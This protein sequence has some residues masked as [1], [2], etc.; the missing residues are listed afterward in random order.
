MEDKLKENYMKILFF[1]NGSANPMLGGIQAV[2]YYL[3]YYFKS[4]GHEVYILSVFR[5][6]DYKNSV[7]IYFPDQENIKGEMNRIFLI[8][9]IQEK[10][11]EIVVNQSCLSP[12]LS[13]F[14]P[15]IKATGIRLVSVFHSQ[16]YGVYGINNFPKIYNAIS[17]K[18]M[19]SIIDKCIHFAFKIK[20]G[21]HFRRILK[22]S[23][24]QVMLSEKFINEFIYFSSRKYKEKVMAI[25]NPLTTSGVKSGKKE[26]IVLFVGRI[27]QGKGVDIILKIWNYI[28]HNEKYKDWK[29][30]IVG[31]GE[32]KKELEK[33]AI[34]M[35][36]VNYSFKGFQKPDIYYDQAKIFCMASTFEGFG[37][38]L[39]EAMYYGAVPL[40]FNSFSNC[41]DIIDDKQNG[42]LVTP[43]SIEEYIQK[44]TGLMEDEKK[45]TTMS[46]CAMH[47]SQEFSIE[48]IGGK[49]LTLFKILLE[50]EKYI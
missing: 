8:D 42:F 6:T 24:R 43:F 32:E 34:E 26:K 9:F 39:I 33:L 13:I 27:C 22:Y 38:V 11:I 35:Q 1:N 25:P 19:R 46:I 23:D 7:Q 12:Q 18:R 20:Y 29:L 30:Y 49:W 47:K 17:C 3:T 28:C 40:A 14:L 16:P 44:L 31:D 5:D 4:L 41:S 48:S 45:W 2:T 50:G 21:K 37:L 36:L 10:H 15:I